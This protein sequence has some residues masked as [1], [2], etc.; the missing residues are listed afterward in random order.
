MCSVAATASGAIFLGGGDG[1]VYQLQYGKRQ[2]CKLVCVS[3]SFLTQLGAGVIPGYLAQRIWNMVPIE[4]M[5]VDNDRHYVYTL[6]QNHSIR[7]W[8]HHPAHLL[9]A[10]V[11]FDAISDMLQICLQVCSQSCL[12]AKCCSVH[13]QNEA[14]D[15]L[16]RH[17][18]LDQMARWRHRS[19]HVCLMCMQQ[20]LQLPMRHLRYHERRRSARPRLFTSHPYR[21]GPLRSSTSWRS[22]LTAGEFS[23][24]PTL[25]ASCGLCHNMLLACIRMLDNAKEQSR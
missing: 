10:A 8:L 21:P 5:V 13:E 6:S 19:L 18:I 20:V 24:K 4:T 12:Q 22:L 9:C 3:R 11:H 16:C 7:V 23:L 25:C 17:I 15:C 2:L 14:C 1:L